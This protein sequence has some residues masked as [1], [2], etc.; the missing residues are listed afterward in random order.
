[1]KPFPRIHPILSVSPLLTCH[2][3]ESVR[4]KRPS[5]PVLP[6]VRL[7]GL[8]MAGVILEDIESLSSNNIFLKKP[9]RCK[10]LQN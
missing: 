5:L 2:V 3:S 8:K 10:L 1:M 9:T 6:S 7:E 4:A